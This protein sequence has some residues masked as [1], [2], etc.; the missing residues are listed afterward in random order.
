MDDQRR[1]QNLASQG[2][3][4]CD[5]GGTSEP[6]LIFLYICSMM[7]EMKEESGNN[8]IFLERRVLWNLRYMKILLKR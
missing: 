5:G 7:H 2:H 8:L 4:Y 3:S 1:K 6:F